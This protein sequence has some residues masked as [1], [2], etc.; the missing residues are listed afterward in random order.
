MQLTSNQYWQ[1]LAE[2]KFT[3]R[4]SRL[5]ASQF[6]K[7]EVLMPYWQIGKTIFEQQQAAS[8]GAKIIDQLASDLRKEFLICRDFRPET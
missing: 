6:A 3:I 2:L 7:A 8:W 5:R 4:Q 1:I